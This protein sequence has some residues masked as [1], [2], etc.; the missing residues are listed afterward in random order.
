MREIKD[1]IAIAL[2]FI[3]PNLA[4]H[5]YENRKD[6]LF[7]IDNEIALEYGESRYQILEG[8]FYN[9]YFTKNGSANNEY[10]LRET[11]IVKNSPR[12]DNVSEGRIS[13]NIYVGSLPLTIYKK[14]TQHEWETNIEVLATKLDLNNISSVDPNFRKNYQFML[15]DIAE[16]CT[17]LLMQINSPVNQNFDVNFNQDH[18]TIYQR[19]AFVNALINT[20]DFS[21]AIQKIISSP[22]TKWREEVEL[23]DTRSLRRLNSYSIR[24]IA[25]RSNRVKLSNPIGKL[26]DIPT[27]IE[28]SHK[29]ETTDTFENRFVKHA[30]EVFLQFCI[31][32]KES[33]IEHG[34]SKSKMEAQILIDKLEN[35]LNHPFFKEIERPTTLKLNS[36]ALQR[37]SGYRELLNA[38]LQYD[39]AA[40]L[41]W[42][43]GEDVYKA[44][45]RDIAVLYEYW[46]FFV[47]YNLIKNKFNLDK[48]NTSYGHL[49]EKTQDGLNV[50]VKSGKL[51]ALDG[52]Y[53]F[54]GKKFRV[55]FSYNRT[56]EG[57]AIYNKPN[58]SNSYS[59]SWTKALRPDY[60]LSI[61][62]SEISDDEKA[63]QE[64]KIVHIHFDSK[65]K[66]QQFAIKTEVDENVVETNENENEELTADE[67]IMDSL[68]REK[69]EERKGN[70]K[71]ADLL[72]MHAYKDAIRRTG[73]AY[74]LYPGTM[75]HTSF[76]GYHELIPGLGAFSIRPVEGENG[77]KELGD[78]LD[79]IILHFNNMA[80]QQ[81]RI[82][83]KIYEIHKNNSPRIIN[84]P[85]PYD[86]LPD[87]T[88]VIV[89][90]YK[91]DEHLAWIQD[92]M[93]YNSRIGKVKGA[94][95]L[96][97][98][99]ISAK[100]L[101]LHKKENNKFF[102][103]EIDQKTIKPTVIASNDILF[104]GKEPRYPKPNQPFY[105]VFNLLK[106]END[107]LG[108][109]YSITK[110][111]NYLYKKAVYSCT[112]TD[113]FNEIGES[114][115]KFIQ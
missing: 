21:E 25:S 40:K 112:L 38:W 60:T 113:F 31:S 69:N 12:K 88:R 73:G 83:T 109:K 81:R 53:E 72:K 105:L 58:K 51:T 89:A 4:L 20:N 56:F 67:V 115:I 57:G 97:A 37:K 100:Y 114:N 15:K 64:E 79:E 90:L 93:K 1:D 71:N 18:K 54:E 44:G 34:Y 102:F 95:E 107:F 16:K 61:W 84:V 32:C 33:F 7:L 82:S 108:V 99:F 39:L 41:I 76:K 52:V 101:I 66:I 111:T 92:R 17:E 30:L 9:Y 8:H 94:I 22:T 26:Y 74:V 23:K 49:I 86:I 77:T 2:D 62:P 65:Y 50:M 110:P 29:V 47:L 91:S 13:P 10:Q 19:F 36:P 87:E 96:T 104:N 103:Y 24:Q 59:G 63:E 46:L 55:K 85:M 14:S 43:G 48:G 3:V 27:K 98:E 78:F 5:I 6:T 28:S 80:S 106:I 68:Q 75:T 35:Y 70:Y 11:I 45:K 42:K